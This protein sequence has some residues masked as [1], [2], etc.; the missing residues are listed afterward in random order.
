VLLIRCSIAQTNNRAA[1]ETLKVIDDC[2]SANRFLN[3]SSRE[4]REHENVM[5]CFQVHLNRKSHKFRLPTRQ[6]FATPQEAA[7]FAEPQATRLE[8][9][10]SA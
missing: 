9:N 2:L 5:Y 10:S 8:E 4:A 3:A 1:G 6:K 7:Q